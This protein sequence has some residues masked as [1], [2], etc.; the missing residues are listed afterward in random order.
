[1]MLYAEGQ[2]LRA[3]SEAV[4]E[5]PDGQRQLLVF[6]IQAK[7]RLCCWMMGVLLEGE[8]YTRTPEG[9]EL[10]IAPP[11]AAIWQFNADFAVLDEATRYHRP[12]ARA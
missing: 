10:K 4:L 1:M 6:F 5:I 8:D 12:Q 11:S 9:I 7:M 3:G 2:L